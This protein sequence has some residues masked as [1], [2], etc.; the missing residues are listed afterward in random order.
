MST[1]QGRNQQNVPERNKKAAP[2]PQPQ[3]T[4]QPSTKSSPYPKKQT[5]WQGPD[6]VDT[7]RVGKGAPSDQIRV[8]LGVHGLD[9]C[10][11]V[12]VVFSPTRAIIGH[13]PARDRS[14]KDG[15]KFHFTINNV[16]DE[17]IKSIK[18]GGAKHEEATAYLFVAH[19]G[20]CSDEE[21]ECSS[22]GIYF[23]TYALEDEIKIKRWQLIKYDP[24][25]SACTALHKVTGDDSVQ[26]NGK[27]EVVVHGSKM[28]PHAWLFGE[29]MT[30]IQ[31][32]A[33]K[34]AAEGRYKYY[35]GHVLGELREPVGEFRLSRR[36]TDVEVEIMDDNCWKVNFDSREVN[37]V[38]K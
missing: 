18:A 21:E 28:L 20:L 17:I 22:Q 26:L 15:S 6:C 27:L 38:L 19:W 36:P 3:P 32:A 2:D 16:V 37:V 24:L 7:V 33:E 4:K 14:D 31:W 34:E 5:Y 23:C 30:L 11:I 1:S 25:S 29:D 9:A 10:P 13:I 35:R 12:I 8:P